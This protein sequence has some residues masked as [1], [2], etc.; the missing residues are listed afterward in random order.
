MSEIK[1]HYKDRSEFADSEIK[2]LN[3]SVNVLVFLRVLVFVAGVTLVVLFWSEAWLSAV[4]G[5]SMAV[6]FGG[7]IKSHLRKK[8]ERSY[9]KEIQLFYENEIR[10]IDGDWSFANS[11][12]EYHVSNHE[13]AHDIDLFGER[14]FF[15]RVN[16]TSLKGG[17]ELLAQ[18]FLSNDTSKIKVLQ[19]ANKELKTKQSFL[20]HFIGYSRINNSEVSP[21]LLRSWLIDFK[22]SLPKFLGGLGIAYS[23]I[24]IG[25]I[26]SFALEFIS[27]TLLSGWLILG[28][29]IVGIWLKQVTKLNAEINKIVSSIKSYGRLLNLIEEESFDSE[30]LVG[31]KK[32]VVDQDHKASDVI[33]HLSRAIDLFNNRNNL[34]VALLGNGFFL[35]DLQTSSR[36]QKWFEKYGQNAVEWIDVLYELDAMISLAIY[37]NNHENYVYP[38]LDTN[39]NING[40]SLGHPLIKQEQCINNN[41]EI[42]PESFL[43]I[44]GANMAGKSTFLRT[45]S[46]AILMTNLGLPVFA[47][48]LKIKPQKLIT[49]MRS[50]DSLLEDESYF[51]AELKRLK[52]IIDKIKEED[53]FIVLDEIL[54][55]TNSKDK[56]EGSKKFVKRL[57]DMGATGIIATHDLG[58]CA[59][60]GELSQVKN[61]YFDAE[62]I[63]DELHFD[64]KMKDGVCKNMNASFLLRKMKIVSD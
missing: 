33:D 12:L 8:D 64:Y 41:V 57:V 3:R 45:I 32:K 24:S 47:E 61:Y 26:I 49:S 17:E 10:G 63:D 28:L 7:F 42:S 36:L 50:S 29:M 18:Q 44:T 30:L 19:Q 5:V 40:K 9:W 54:K 22:P 6:L 23:V 56:E 25:V 62:I 15:Q 13:F 48:E 52:Y 2:K 43:I 16:R 11:G 38:I 31:L 37:A 46:L 20:E 39:A 4:I 21:K 27:G 1:I 60:E 58:L 53:Y 34:I 14:S 51:F 55:G 35:W 59:I